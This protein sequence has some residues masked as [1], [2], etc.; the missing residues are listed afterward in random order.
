MKLYRCR[1]CARGEGGAHSHQT[2][3]N[4]RAL[5]QPHL[6]AGHGQV[7]RDGHAREAGQVQVAQVEELLEHGEGPT[8]A[9]AAAPEAVIER[10]RVLLHLSH[11]VWLV[12]GVTTVVSDAF[13]DGASPRCGRTRPFTFAIL[14]LLAGDAP[15]GRMAGECVR[16]AGQRADTARRVIRGEREFVGGVVEDLPHAAWRLTRVQVFKRGSGKR[17]GM[18][19]LT[20]NAAR[21][22]CVHACG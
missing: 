7:L 5:R 2:G 19:S 3:V 4:S 13:S 9:T 12:V 20:D 22:A 18:A 1:I 14:A 6:C 16:G 11:L 8:A 21:I 10:G 17:A 15:R